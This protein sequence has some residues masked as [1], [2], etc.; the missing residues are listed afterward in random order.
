MSQ[1]RELI[2]EPD[3]RC[4]SQEAGIFLAQ[5]ED[6]HAD[7]E[8]AIR[9]AGV[10]EIGWQ[11]QP[12]ANTIGM[13][14][15][16]VALSQV[17]LVDIGVR[18]METSDLQGTLG[19]DEMADGMPLPPDG[20]PPAHLTGRT[21][22]ELIALLEKAR[23]HAA[24]FLA[25]IAE[26]DL[27]RRSEREPKSGTRYVFNVRWMLYHMVEHLSAHLGQVQLLRAAYRQALTSSRA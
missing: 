20:M 17:H 16:H 3:P 25:G 19:M 5:L 18:M 21:A 6:L 13:L 2:L 24:H 15:T 11:V 23:G 4:R 9:D 10:E 14:V 27:D 26:P 1:P 12:G 8:K 22:E 7:L